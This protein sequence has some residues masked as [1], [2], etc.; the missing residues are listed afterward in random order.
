MADNNKIK[1]KEQVARI[2]TN[3]K[4]STNRAEAI[5][6]SAKRHAASGKGL[7]KRKGK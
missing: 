1:T 4:V 3:L 7:T 5:I 6:S 2:A